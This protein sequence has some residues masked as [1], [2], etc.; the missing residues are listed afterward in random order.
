MV[1]IRPKKTATLEKGGCFLWAFF[2]FFVINKEYFIDY[3]LTISFFY[4]IICILNRNISN[5]F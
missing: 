5:N 1:A 2:Y 4:C 3:I